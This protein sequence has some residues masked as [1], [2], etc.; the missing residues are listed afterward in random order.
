MNPFNFVRWG[1]PNT[2]LVGVNF[3][4]VTSSQAGRLVQIN[5][6]LKF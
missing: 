3:G 1:N 6:T 2:S 4:K 5:G